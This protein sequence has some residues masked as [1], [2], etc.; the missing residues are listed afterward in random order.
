[1]TVKD[2]ADICKKYNKK[3]TTIS[4]NDPVP[5]L[6][7]TLSNQKIKKRVLSFYTSLD[8]LIKDMIQ[9]WSDRDFINSNE[10]IEIGRDN[11]V[12]KRGRNI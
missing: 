7:Y 2:V 3:I 10:V 1:M 6:G 5:N 8:K 4:T 9:S 12:D 11:F